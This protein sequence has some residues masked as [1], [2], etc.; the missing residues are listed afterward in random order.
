ML[1]IYNTLS[2]KK[3]EI[4]PLKG[5][6]INL[7]VC[8]PTVY[9]FIHLGNA[10][11]VIILDCF[12][13]YLKSLGFKVFYLQNITDIDDKII[14]RAKEKGVTPKDLAEA[15]LQEYFTTMKAL[16]ITSVQKYAN[17]TEYIPEIIS[18]VERLQEKGFAYKLEDGIYFDI[19]RFSDYGKLSGRTALAAED[20][21]SRIDY[22]KNKKN[23]GDFCL[24][25][26]ETP[27]EPSWPSPFG[28]GRPGWHIEDTAITEAFFGPQ[29]DIHGGGQ[30]IMFPH[31]EA[32]VTQMESLSGKA[33]LAKYWMHVGLL[34]IGGQKMSKSL[35]NFV[36]ANDFLKRYPY[37]QLRFWIAKNLWHSPLDYS[38]S[39][40]IEVKTAL[41]KIEEFLRKLKGVKRVS[42]IASKEITQ[43]TKKA[44][45]AFYESLGDDFNTPKA[46]AVIFELI[47]V[48][49]GFLDKDALSKKQAKEL[50]TFFK[51]INK[52]FD[53]IDF[54]K[55][56]KAS[57][58]AEVT[59]LVKEREAHR[60]VGEFE[61]AD[62]A[63]VEIEKYG[64]VVKDT[65]EGPVVQKM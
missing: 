57:I 41:E 15:F 13:K 4:V 45:D 17:A 61:K 14:A 10:R 51:E 65:K 58:P 53:I 23:R 35:N 5:K 7:F 2:G 30:D 21:V 12:A 20:S 49:N 43:A 25:K 60:K 37:Q 16:N 28:A 50:F 31:H 11:T 39:T 1:K 59:R 44:H 27:G 55:L 54:K 8:G 52:I 46:F 38:D 19:S 47:K 48:M 56:T 32:E 18:Q 3:E 40:M 9:D 33:P 6:K 62:T 26:F 63:R 64:Y 34:T 22:S 24:W 42:S 29:Y 36:M